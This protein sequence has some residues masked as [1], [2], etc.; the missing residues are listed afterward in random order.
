MAQSSLL[1]RHDH[2]PPHHTPP[3]R[4]ADTGGT[5]AGVYDALVWG[6]VCTILDARPA[7][8]QNNNGGG[9]NVRVEGRRRR[10]LRNAAGGVMSCC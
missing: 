9:G 4:Q 5:D 3:P 7:L 2:K 10:A 8:L 6:M 1:S